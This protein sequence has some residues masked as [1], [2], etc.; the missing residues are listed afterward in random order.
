LSQAKINEVGLFEDKLKCR[1]FKVRI[2]EI[3]IFSL[4]RWRGLARLYSSIFHKTEEL[5][6]YFIFE[7]LYIKVTSEIFSD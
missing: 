7:F 4:N 1:I 2:N 6:A 5:Q 3:Y